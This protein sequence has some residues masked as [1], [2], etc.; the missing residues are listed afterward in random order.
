MLISYQFDRGIGNSSQTCKSFL[1]F[2]KDC[3]SIQFE[4]VTYYWLL[5]VGKMVVIL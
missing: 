1:S 3:V 4:D 2:Q 5:N